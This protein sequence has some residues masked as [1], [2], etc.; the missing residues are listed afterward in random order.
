MALVESILLARGP[1]A[2]AARTR[3]LEL[4]FACAFLEDE[5]LLPPSPTQLQ[6]Q[7]W[8]DATPLAPAAAAA[9]DSRHCEQSARSLAL[10]LWAFDSQILKG[11]CGVSRCIYPLRDRRDGLLTAFT[12]ATLRV[13]ETVLPEATA[14]VLALAAQGAAP[15]GAGCSLGRHADADTPAAYDRSIQA[16]AALSGVLECLHAI[17]TEAYTHR[18]G[19]LAPHTAREMSE[20][21]GMGWYDVNAPGLFYVERTGADEAEWRAAVRL[22]AAAEVTAAVTLA[23]GL[24]SV[25][26]RRQHPTTTAEGSR[27]PGAVSGVV[28]EGEDASVVPELMP[29]P[30]WYT[31]Q[32]VASLIVPEYLEME[33]RQK[34]RSTA[35]LRWSDALSA[36]EMW[37]E[38]KNG[39]VVEEQGC[40]ADT[41]RAASAAL[42]MWR[43]W[44]DD[45]AGRRTDGWSEVMWELPRHMRTRWDYYNFDYEF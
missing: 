38:K 41:D 31:L 37:E 44:D 17:V 23:E 27:T 9:E 16:A 20:W 10:R 45:V 39:D 12:G 33:S 35:A 21:W 30:L 26:R 19:L 24:L 43:R 36:L 7:S 22:A 8:E 40:C 11:I 28:V 13:V 2:V 42:K 1:A 34:G 14:S 32:V 18:E 5:K 4:A 25:E 6:Q 3:L 15:L 29:A